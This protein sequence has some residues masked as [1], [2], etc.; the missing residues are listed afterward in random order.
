MKNQV[1]K[2]CGIDDKKIALLIYHADWFKMF[3]CVSV[4]RI[5]NNELS[6]FRQNLHVCTELGLTADQGVPCHWN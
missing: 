3:N 2:V 4:A 5:T 6:N 1:L